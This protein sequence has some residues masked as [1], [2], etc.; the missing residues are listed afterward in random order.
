MS[1]RGPK[2]QIWKRMHLPDRFWAKVAI[3]S[4]SDGCWKWTGAVNSRGYG[5][6][7]GTFKGTCNY[8]HVLMYESR[9]GPVTKG[10]QVD[11]RCHTVECLE[12]ERCEHRRCVNPEH[13][14]ELTH[15]ENQLR[16]RTFVAGYQP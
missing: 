15:L 11:H 5:Q 12:G 4:N 8:A 13:L 14:Q 1:K 3:P 7:A 10:K 2:P 6:L 16:G 9:Y